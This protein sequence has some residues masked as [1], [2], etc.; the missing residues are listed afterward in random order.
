MRK[1]I[2]LTSII[3]LALVLTGCGNRN[4]TLKQNETSTIN[5]Q[6]ASKDANQRQ[7]PEDSA[8]KSAG[9]TA[10][11]QTSGSTAIVAKSENIMSSSEKEELLKQVDKELDSLFNNINNLEDTQD[12]DLDL[13]Q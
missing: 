2:V 1:I 10:S 9:S 12:S 7:N 13:T 6:Q 5:M 11:N 4:K 3:I 8:T